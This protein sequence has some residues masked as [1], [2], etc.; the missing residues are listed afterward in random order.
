MSKRMKLDLA[1]CIVLLRL[2]L[3]RFLLCLRVP[4]P[5]S[6]FPL[7]LGNTPLP[8]SGKSRA[9][10]TQALEELRFS[11]RFEKLDAKAFLLSDEEDELF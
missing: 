2:I 8:L 10:L 7:P 1:E 4:F 3:K 9:A 5:R 11:A 6:A